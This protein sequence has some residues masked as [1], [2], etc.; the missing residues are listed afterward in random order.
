SSRTRRPTPCS[1][2][3]TAAFLLPSN[4]D[5]RAFHEGFADCVALFQHFT[6][7]DIV[8]HQMATTRG[9]ISLEENLLGQLATQFGRATGRRGA[10]R[11]AIGKAGPDGKWRP[12][13]PQPEEYQT[14]TEAH[15]RGGILVAAVF[16]A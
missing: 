5:V 10:L 11:D 6:F 7:P 2:G 12:H 14:M 13:D 16:D 8:R 9:D 3:C 4:P 15:D 1:T